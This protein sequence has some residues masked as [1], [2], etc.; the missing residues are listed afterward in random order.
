MAAMWDP[1]TDLI[2]TSP[3]DGGENKDSLVTADIFL[4][5]CNKDNLIGLKRQRISN[6]YELKGVNDDADL[7]GFDESGS[8]RT[9]LGHSTTGPQKDYWSKGLLCGIKQLQLGGIQENLNGA[10][11]QK[12]DGC[13]ERLGHEPPFGIGPGK[14]NGAR[15]ES[16]CGKEDG[17]G[18]ALPRGTGSKKLGR[19]NPQHQHGSD[20][21]PSVPSAAGLRNFEASSARDVVHET[22]CATLTL[23]DQ[24]DSRGVFHACASKR[25]APE[26]PGIA[27]DCTSERTEGRGHAEVLYADGG[28]DGMV[29]RRSPVAV[30]AEPE[31]DSLTKEGTSWSGQGYQHLPSQGKECELKEGEDEDDEKL[32]PGDDISST[33]IQA[34]EESSISLVIFSENYA[35]STW[36][37]N[38]LVE[39]IQCMKQDQRIV[40]PVF[41]NVVPSDVRHQNNS[42][43]E[44]FDKHQHRLKGNLMKVQ[45]WRFALKEASNL[46]GFH[47]PS[48]YQ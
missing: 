3:N 20:P 46:S 31:V 10:S 1:A 17:L 41:Y 30:D 32:H 6:Q 36:C 33:L 18:Q 45:S 21:G 42:F 9:L 37:M 39:V 47:Y 4:N 2:G 28:T 22:G 19:E 40:I 27:D 15:N 8:E 43:K 26:R 7:G 25:G 34:I 12:G 35:S 44:A 16:E 13:E 5:D 11:L 29:V 23:G 24:V 38:E 48:K 14:Q